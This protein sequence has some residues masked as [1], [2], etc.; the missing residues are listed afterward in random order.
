MSGVLLLT[1]PSL[2]R[3]MFAGTDPSSGCPIPEE[4]VNTSVSTKDVIR[5]VVHESYCSTESSSMTRGRG[6]P[7]SWQKWFFLS[8]IH[9]RNGG[10][11][12]SGP[13]NNDLQPAK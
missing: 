6:R 2:E 9:S 12:P 4:T 13:L 11:P 8:S 5:I 7:A 3:S 1:S 10:E